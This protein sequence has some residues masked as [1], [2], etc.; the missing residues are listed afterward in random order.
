MKN[1]AITEDIHR[2]LVKFALMKHTTIRAVV[3]RAIAE[4]TEYDS[5]QLAV[6]WVPKPPVIPKDIEEIIGA[7]AQHTF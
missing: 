1:V 4:F 7:S 6:K 5:R 3:E 2:H